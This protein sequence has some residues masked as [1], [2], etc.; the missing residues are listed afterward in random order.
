MAVDHDLISFVDLTFLNPKSHQP[1]TA[2]VVLITNPKDARYMVA[3]HEPLERMLT[4]THIRFLLFNTSAIRHFTARI[5]ETVLTEKPKVALFRNSKRKQTSGHL[6]TIPWAPKKYFDGQSHSLVVH[7]EDEQG[8]IGEHHVLFRLDFKTEPIRGP[9]VFVMTSRITYWSKMLFLMTYSFVTVFLLF[10]PKMLSSFLYA[11]KQY[12]RWRLQYSAKLIQMDS[13]VPIPL[14]PITSLL[15]VLL[16]VK[17]LA[18]LRC[19]LAVYDFKYFLHAS[20]FRL[21]TLASIPRTFYP[22]YFYALYIVVGPYFIGELVPSSLKHEL[23]NPNHHKFGFMYVY[24]MYIDGH[25]IPLLDTWIFGFLELAYI[26]LP[27]VLY[28]SFCIT[29]PEQLY[30]PFKTLTAEEKRNVF[31]FPARHERRLYPLH[32]NIH[33]RLLVAATVLYQLVNCFFISIFYG[34]MA[35]VLSPGKTWFVLWSCWALWRHRWSE[36]GVYVDLLTDEKSPKVG[37]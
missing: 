36:K 9:G 14:P 32:R 6:F 12:H 18:Y 31:F 20:L 3:K 24:G 25:W 21:V 8:R 11:T 27:L 15:S 2:P 29:P 28:L 13:P 10:I 35:V 26:L 34:P 22:M 16:R 4:S 1:D 7:V 5:D 23:Y 33:V 37:R 19:K 30:A 17:L